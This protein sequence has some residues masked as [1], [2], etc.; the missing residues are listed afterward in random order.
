[1]EVLD[2]KIPWSQKLIDKS[3]KLR[4]IKLTIQVNYRFWITIKVQY[5]VMNFIIRMDSKYFPSFGK[6]RIIWWDLK[7]IKQFWVQVY[8]KSIWLF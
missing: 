3:N 1:M 2:I 6:M 4:S 8:Q 7:S 5:L